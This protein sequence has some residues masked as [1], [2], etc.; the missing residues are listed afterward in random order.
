MM[1]VVEQSTEWELAVETEVL[2]KI[3]LIAP[4]PT[5]NLTWPELGN[6]GGKPAANRKANRTED[7][8]PK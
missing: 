7:L 1:V 6:R 3:G 4:L 5:T 8:C 2:Q